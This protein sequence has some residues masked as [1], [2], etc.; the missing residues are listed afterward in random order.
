MGGVS[1][2]W[3]KFNYELNK[4]VK[5]LCSETFEKLVLMQNHGCYEELINYYHE[6]YSVFEQHDDNEGSAL[7]LALTLLHIVRLSIIKEDYREMYFYGKRLI[8]LLKRMLKKFPDNADYYG[9]LGTILG[10]FANKTSTR[11]MFKKMYY[12]ISGLSYYKRAV[13]IDA[14]NKYVLLCGLG[15]YLNAP[16]FAG[17]NLEKGINLADIHNSLYEYDMWVSYLLANVYIKSDFKESQ[18]IVKDML[19]RDSKNV[20]AYDL[21]KK[22]IMLRNR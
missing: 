19:N 1:K 9:L 3:V 4:G 7:A 11:L 2:S 18:N 22:F 5:M 17:G 13:K 21:E 10:T 14:N 8:V 6:L 16:P 12:G 15:H 20:F